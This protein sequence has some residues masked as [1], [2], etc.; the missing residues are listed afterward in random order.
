MGFFMSK[1]LNQERDSVELAK[2]KQETD[3]VE[4]L[5]LFID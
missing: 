2:L 4:D 5:P 3:E 1:F